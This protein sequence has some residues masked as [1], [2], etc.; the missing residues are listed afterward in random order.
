MDR[1]V[2]DVGIGQLTITLERWEN[3]DFGINT[4]NREIGFAGSLPKRLN[5]FDSIFLPYDS[6][7]WLALFLSAIAVFSLLLTFEWITGWDKQSDPTFKALSLTVGPLL[8][9]SQPSRMLNRSQYQSKWFVIGLWLFLGYFLSMAYESNL[10]AT[11]TIVSYER[12]IDSPEGVIESDL[13]VYALSGTA[14]AE[15]L[16]FSPNPIYRSIFDNQ[17]VAKKGLRFFG[18]PVEERNKAIQE[19][20]GFLVSTK[21]DA[22]SN[23]NLRFFSEAHFIGSSSWFY[24]R[25]SQVKDDF[26]LA[27]QRL[28][29]AGILQHL[30]RSFVEQRRFSNEMSLNDVEERG[31]EPI[32]LEHYLP[33]LLVGATGM[34]LG[35][36]CFCLEL[37]FWKFGDLVFKQIVSR[38]L[39]I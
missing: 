1:F 20:R 26:N 30:E 4:Y 25:G 36:F 17:V 18:E 35:V 6:T 16:Q 7:T 39:E 9:E 37:L 28:I 33:V 29:E 2:Y 21:I 38:V 13:T 15:S 3:V 32:T 27:L 34:V 31:Y 10:L 14:L 23:P 8:N 19:G 24:T 11:L 12:P 5:V 22:Q